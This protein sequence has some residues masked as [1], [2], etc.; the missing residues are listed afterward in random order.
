MYTG[1]NDKIFLLYS[2]LSLISSLP[3]KTAS[4][5]DG[6]SSFLL[7]ATASISLPLFPHEWKTSN[8]VP[9]PKCSPPSSSSSNFCPISL[10]SLVSKLLE[11]H[12]HSIL[13][14]FCFNQN[15]ISP[16]Q[17]GFLASRST[18]T[19]L[20]FTPPT[21]SSLS[22]KP[23]LLYVEFSLILKK[24]DSVPHSPLLKLLQSYDFPLF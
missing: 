4:G 12:V 24:L 14:D 23:I 21:R 11:K 22:S 1:N 17:F 3:S 2:S 20:Y 8:I 16:Y 5:P 19:R 18:T 15:L 6:I 13:L 10:L 9:I 7:K